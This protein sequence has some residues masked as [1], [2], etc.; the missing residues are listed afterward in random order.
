MNWWGNEIP[1]TEQLHNF[2]ENS[3]KYSDLVL[4]H[5]A[6]SNMCLRKPTD[7][8]RKTLNQV[9][10]IGNYKYWCAGHH[11]I[12]KRCGNDMILYKDIVR[13]V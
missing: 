7:L 5:D 13:I 2:V 3:E 1:S 6:P 12:D 4:T 11:H 10:D 8:L 9:Y